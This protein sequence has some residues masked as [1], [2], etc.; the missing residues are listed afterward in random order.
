MKEKT[1]ITLSGDILTAIDRLAGS[2]QSRSAFIERV[3]RE[4]LRE[5]ARAAV[6]ARDLE[7]INTAAQRLNA[8]AAEVM[9]YQAP[10]E[11]E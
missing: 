11:A 8:E 4:F 5:R 9:E 7:R 10:G 2:K 3:L 1:S 6:Q